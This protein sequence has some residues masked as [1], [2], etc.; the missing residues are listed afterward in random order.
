MPKRVISLLAS[1]ILI[2]GSASCTPS[3]RLGVSGFHLVQQGGGFRVETSRLAVECD[4]D[5]GL[6]LFLKKDGRW[7]TISSSGGLPAVT[8]VRAG[9][10][11]FAG[12]KLVR[13]AEATVVA[14][15]GGRDGPARDVH[16][17]VSSPFGEAHR[18]V[19]FGRDPSNSLGVYLILDFP[20]RYPDVVVI[21]SRVINLAAQSLTI[22]EIS[23]ASLAL[24]PSAAPRGADE[25]LFWSLQGG[26][27]KWGGDYILPLRAGFSQDNYT[28]PKGNGNGGGFPFVDLWRPEMGVAVALLEPQ[29]ALAWVP[30]NVTVQGQAEVDVLTRPSAAIPPSETYQA[31]PVMVAV[32]AGD[33]YDPVVRYRQLMSDLGVAPLNHFS[34]DDY[35]PAWC[36]WGYQRTFTL[37]DIYQK[38]DQMKTMG[39]RE[40]ILDDGWFTRF[41]D[42]EPAPQKFPRGEA[43]MKA[44]VDRAHTEGLKFRLWWSPGSADPGS[45]IDKQHADWFILDSQGKREKASWNAYYLCPAYKPVQDFTRGLVER[46]VRGWGVDSFKLDGVDLNHAPL[47]YNPAHHHA[48]AE[49]SFAEWPALF[50]EIGETA[51]AIRPDFRI[52][53]CPC[54]ITPTYQL[55]TAFEQP[56]TSDPFDYQ[57]TERV[58]FLKAWFGPTAPVLEEYVGLFGQKEPNGT[59]YTFR[60][61]LYPRALG[62]GAVISTFSPVLGQSHAEWTA[63]YNQQGLAYGEYLNRYDIGWDNPEGHV[64]RKGRRL[65]YAFFTRLPGGEFNG[66]ISLRGLSRERYRVVDYVHH[67]DF[68]EV[69]GPNPT[70]TVGFHDSLLLRVEPLSPPGGA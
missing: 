17:K 30:V 4:R 57:V 10:N 33:F 42:W 59:P 2:L 68:G 28:G 38:M 31:P 7:A 35:A 44:L 13:P 20:T 50:R 26:G 39:M 34:P 61:E 23:Q 45:S 67:H 14:A 51:R 52:E 29:P 41:G 54:G 6:R 64:I 8:S 16:Q 15:G 60:V 62:T 24:S 47:C 43:D 36:T 22:D 56:V 5:L 55:A 37:P 70:L 66:N 53:L 32:H 63:I 12:L 27:Y 25:D 46:F 9:G 19:A 40:L 1:V 48:H 49:E 65:Y 21:A 3:C 18:V 11:T 58:K 69:R